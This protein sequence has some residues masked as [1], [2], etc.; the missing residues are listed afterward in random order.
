MSGM[1]N[2]FDHVMGNFV[3][4]PTKIAIGWEYQI[5]CSLPQACIFLN[6]NI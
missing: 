5:A 1:F 2:R 6:S 3:C 4:E